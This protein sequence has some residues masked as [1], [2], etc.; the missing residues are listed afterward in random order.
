MKSG[1]SAGIPPNGGRPPNDRSR[2][3]FTQRQF[4]HRTS[5]ICVKMDKKTSINS[6]SSDLWLQQPYTLVRLPTVCAMSCSS[7]T[8]IRN[9]D[10]LKKSGAEHYRHCYQWMEKASACL[11]SHKGPI[12]RLFP[13]NIEQLD[14]WINCQLEWRK[15]G[16][17]MLYVCYFN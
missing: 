10:E 15:S 13:V 14:N 3:H 8:P 9:V 17:N 5:D 4:L 16:Q 11:C 6:I 7:G 1:K 2:F 12:F